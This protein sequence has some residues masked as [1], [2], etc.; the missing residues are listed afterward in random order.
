MAN[1]ELGRNQQ[2]PRW[3]QSVASD[4]VGL[5]TL[6]ANLFFIG[7]AGSPTGWV[8]VDAG[9]GKCADLIIASAEERFGPNA[10][11]EAII[12]THAHFDHVGALEQL[13]ERW[14]VPVYAHELELP[15]LTGRDDYP[16]F[17]P[18][19]GGGAMAWLSF[20]YPRKALNLGTRVQSLPSDGSVP[21]LPDWR[22]IHTPG[23]TPGHISL[24][25]DSD[26]VLV[27][28]DA[29]I[30]TKQESAVAALLQIPH[31]RRPPA[32]ATIDW[33]AA[34]RSVKALAA[35]E[36]E[37]LATGHG[38]PLRGEEMRQQLRELADEFVRIGV[39]NRGR[40]I[41]LPVEADETG[42]KSVPP[43]PPSQ[44][45]KVLGGV[46]VL[47]AL[48]LWKRSRGQRP[49]STLAMNK[50]LLAN[51]IKYESVPPDDT[52]EVVVS[53]KQLRL[54]RGQQFDLKPGETLRVP[55]KETFI[56][57]K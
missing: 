57:K 12:L 54:K 1:T 18:S 24:F 52:E 15:F 7:E 39:P 35:L 43:A 36:P 17:D 6:I 19:V 33:Y 42:I 44:L 48:L 25:R 3:A 16:P 30:T 23:H 5:R 38:K 50:K 51:P 10:R 41:G 28:G 49:Q 53:R 14:N 22:W 37:V 29:V 20:T 21:Y 45:P 34:R 13:L 27:A 2:L 26:K 31:V 4:V 40:Y 55:E 46:A 47:A 32:Y 9:V 56:V 11:P 8:L